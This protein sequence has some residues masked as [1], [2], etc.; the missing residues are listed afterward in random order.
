MEPKFHL[1]FGNQWTKLENGWKEDKRCKP[2]MGHNTTYVGSFL[3][4]IFIMN[5]IYPLYKTNK[6]KWCC[7]NFHLEQIVYMHAHICYMILSFVNQHM[8][9]SISEK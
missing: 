1:G 7:S 6:Y 3:P 8:F 2:Q 5:W 4:T 9:Q